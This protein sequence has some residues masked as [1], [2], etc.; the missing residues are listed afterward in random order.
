MSKLLANSAGLNEMPKSSSGELISSITRD[1]RQSKLFILST[2]VGQKSLEIVFFDC[3][4][5]PDW[6]Q[7][8]IKNTVSS[9][10]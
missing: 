5:S 8:A 7:M 6:R 2:N 1:R 9:D 3:H 4:L 10:F